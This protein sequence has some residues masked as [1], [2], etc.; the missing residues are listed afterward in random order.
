MRTDDLIDLLTTD[1]LPVD[2]HVAAKKLASGLSIA[3]PVS[4]AMMAVVL[5]P[6]PALAEYLKQPMFWV[7][8]AT[9]LLMA[10]F[11]M[12]LVMRSGKPGQ[13]TGSFWSVLG[14]CILFL[15][16]L[17]LFVLVGAPA[18]DARSLMLSRTWRV[19]AENIAVLSLPVFL[20]AI[21]VLRGMA[22]TRLRLAGAGAGALGGSCGAAVYA[23]HCPELAAPFIAIWYVLGM[24]LPVVAGA[25]LG[26]R[27]LRW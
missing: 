26:P 24:V 2:R 6:N 4:L 15:W 5:H 27:L 7:K 8:F 3:I 10:L 25:V 12:Q 20:A 21:W 17:G 9:P 11:A 22:P 19:C 1:T 18:E 23:I 14:V 13:R 16:A